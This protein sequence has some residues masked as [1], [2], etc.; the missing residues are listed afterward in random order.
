MDRGTTGRNEETGANGR[1]FVTVTQGAE[2]A[3]SAR[4]RPATAEA[5][6][7]A[8]HPALDTAM[9]DVVPV[10]EALSRKEQKR[11]ALY[12]SRIKVHPKDVRGT[13][14]TIKWAVLAACLAI[15]Y[16]GPWLRWDRGPDAPDQALLMDF[17]NRKFYLFWIEIWPQ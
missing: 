1:D 4:P 10:E 9:T 16:I 2:P 13:I 5:P 12:A 8:A 17:T 14:R 11:E 6:R 15:Y 3:V 7:R